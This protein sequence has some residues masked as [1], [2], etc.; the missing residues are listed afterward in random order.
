M[1]YINSSTANISAWICFTLGS[2]CS[3]H[4]II[5]YYAWLHNWYHKGSVTKTWYRSSQ[6]LI[7]AILPIHTW[8]LKT[9]KSSFIN[10][11]QLFHPS[12]DLTI[13]ILVQ[14]YNYYKSVNSCIVSIG[15][16]QNL[17]TVWEKEQAWENVMGV[18]LSTQTRGRES[19]LVLSYYIPGNFRTLLHTFML[20]DPHYWHSS[21]HHHLDYYHY[22]IAYKKVG[23]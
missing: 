21:S 13:N 11:Y 4:T 12:F 16:A 19:R 6:I 10:A 3:V 7:N 15:I 9:F 8:Q 2:N 1:V 17:S 18:R 20:T 23:S 5:N 22:D 14:L